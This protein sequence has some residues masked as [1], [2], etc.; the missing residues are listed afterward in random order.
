MREEALVSL[1][2]EQQ[3][4]DLAYNP[5]GGPT[6]L[7]EAARTAGCDRVADGLEVLVAQGAQS[8]ERWTGIAAPRD[9]MDAALRS[10]P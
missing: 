10:S 4:V 7:V 2:P 1:R 8:F 9:V 3:I 5:D 6:M